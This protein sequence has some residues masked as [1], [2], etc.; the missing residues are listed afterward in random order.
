MFSSH[1]W[2]VAII[3]DEAFSES[4]VK[5]PKKFFFF[6]LL[7]FCIYY[8]IFIFSELNFLFFFNF[9]LNFILF[10]NFTILY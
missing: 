1:V 5:I 3:L 9:F 2:L 10:L 8:Y 7:Q 6:D 4:H